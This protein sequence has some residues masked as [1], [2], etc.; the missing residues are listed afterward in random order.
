MTKVTVDYTKC[1]N[2]AEAIYKQY[3]AKQLPTKMVGYAVLKEWV[4]IASRVLQIR[5]NL[6]LSDHIAEIIQKIR[7]YQHIDY[8]DPPLAIEDGRGQSG[9]Y[10]INGNN[11]VNALEQTIRFRLVPG[12]TQVPV[13]VVPDEM[14]P[15]GKEERKQTLQLLGTM[16]NRQ[17]KVVRG[18]SK[19]DIRDMIT[20]DMR[21]GIN[22]QDYAYQDAKSQSAHLPLATIRELVGKVLADSA[23]RNMNAKMKFRELARWEVNAIATQRQTH[24]NFVQVATVTKDKIFGTLAGVLQAMVEHDGCDSVHLI[25]H[26]KN[27]SDIRTLKVPTK[28]KIE[29]F[30]KLVNFPVTYE[31]IDDT[32]FVDQSDAA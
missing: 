31:F 28:E 20:R 29:A 32:Q 4:D 8:A 12:L 17:P 14:L 10:L 18:M 7:Y 22:I 21:E 24:T 15:Q 3:H 27:Y 26:F 5:E 11:T 25:F 19:N 23:A 9:L 2:L 1:A 16:M 6:K 13:V 30:T